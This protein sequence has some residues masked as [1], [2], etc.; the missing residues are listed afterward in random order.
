MIKPGKGGDEL[1]VHISAFP[2]TGVAPAP[3]EPLSFA[4]A[5]GKDGKKWACDIARL[6]PSRPCPRAADRHAQARSYSALVTA[7]LVVLAVTAALLY[8]TMRT[9]GDD[10]LIPSSV[11]TTKAGI[12]ATA[13][14]HRT[15]PVAASRFARAHA[16]SCDTRTRCSQMT[17]CTEAKFFLKNCPGAKMDGDADGIPC[18][19]QW[20]DRGGDLR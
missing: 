4:V 5:I 18:E 17:S 13:L 2:R 1:P 8:A 19:T 11:A 7:A 20:C 10:A 15:D 16:A 6:Q 3:G 12:D 14:P 9:S